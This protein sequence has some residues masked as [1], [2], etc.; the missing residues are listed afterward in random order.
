[1]GSVL[2]DPLA[3]G[4]AAVSGTYAAVA[5][6]DVHDPALPRATVTAELSDIPLLLVMPEYD[7]EWIV[8]ASME[9]LERCATENRTVDVIEVPGGHHG[10]ET[11]DD[12]DE[13]RDAVRRSIDWGGPGP[14]AESASST[15]GHRHDRTFAGEQISLFGAVQSSHRIAALPV[16]IG[17]SGATALS[18]S[19]SPA[20][21]GVPTVAVQAER[22]R[23]CRE[24]STSRD[25]H[26]GH[27]R[28]VR[29]RHWRH[30]SAPDSNVFRRPP[31]CAA[32]QRLA[33][34]VGS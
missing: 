20:V 2:A 9:L 10:F 26:L 30:R 13:A 28:C 16:S 8:T 25:G 34:S 11:V 15:S 31:A 23:A 14:C 27:Q 12:T 19:R 24:V 6:P 32:D 1:M 3:W 7:F 4:V 29:S 17:G 18:G 5:H 22:A 33:A 21:Y